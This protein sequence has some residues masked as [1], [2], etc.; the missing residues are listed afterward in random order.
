MKVSKQAIGAEEFS[1]AGGTGG[2]FAKNPTPKPRAKF[3]WLC[4][5]KLWQGKIHAEMVVD[6]HHRILHKMCVNRV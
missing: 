3:C 4:G 6:G 1:A 2:I 5:K